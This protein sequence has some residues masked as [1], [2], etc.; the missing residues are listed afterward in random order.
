[1]ELPH[2]PLV[3]CPHV[4]LPS[5]KPIY[6]VL[7]AVVLHQLFPSLWLLGCVHVGVHAFQNFTHPHASPS[8]HVSWKVWNA[9]HTYMRHYAIEN[10]YAPY[11]PPCAGLKR[12]HNIG[13]HEV[14][15]ILKVC[16]SLSLTLN[17]DP[18]TYFRFWICSPPTRILNFNKVSTFMVFILMIGELNREYSWTLKTKSGKPLLLKFNF[19]LIDIM[20]HIMS[21]DIFT[22]T[23]HMGSFVLENW[24]CSL[25]Y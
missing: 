23:Q 7:G 6:P 16:Q 11:L 19:N 17:Y 12:F 8:A 9:V 5:Y 21:F 15:H 22:Y 3:C 13:T 14:S 25:E 20:N 18:W 1:M 4:W 10:I 2:T 24:L